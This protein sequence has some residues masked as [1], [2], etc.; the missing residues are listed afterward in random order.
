MDISVACDAL[1]N[2]RCLEIQYSNYIRVVE[3]H[4]VGY[5]K[6][7]QPIMRAWQVSGGSA[8]SDTVGWKIF[9]LDE[10]Q[11]FNNTEIESQAPRTGYR[12]GDPAIAEIVCEI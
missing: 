1:S 12:R 5:S 8:Q 7:E 6:T 10:I 9:R 2:S 4:T 3:V 11:S